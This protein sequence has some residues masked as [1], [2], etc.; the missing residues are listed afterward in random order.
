VR[1]QFVNGLAQD[2]WAAVV[3]DCGASGFISRDEYIGKEEVRCT[4]CGSHVRINPSL[5]L[6][7]TRRGSESLDGPAP[8]QLEGT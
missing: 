2:S 8:S 7:L 4:F 3:C 1:V 6:P 5:M